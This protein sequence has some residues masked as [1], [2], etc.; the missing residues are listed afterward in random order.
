[1]SYTKPPLNSIPFNFTSSGYS[2]IDLSNIEFNFLSSVLDSTI[3]ATITGTPLYTSEAYT[4]PKKCK[5]VAIQYESGAVQVLSIP[6]LYGGIRDLVGFIR[7]LSRE[8]YNLSSSVFGVYSGYSDITSFIEGFLY[9]GV[10]SD[11]SSNIYIDSPANL[12]SNV[13]S[14]LPSL[15]SA[16]LGAAP[17]GTLDGTIHGYQESDIFANVVL[18]TPKELASYINTDLPY[19]I[20]ADIGVDSP[21]DITFSVFSI[22]SPSINASV[23]GWTISNIRANIGIY[24]DILNNISGYISST[25]PQDISGN[26]AGAPPTNLTATEVG[27]LPSSLLTYLHGWQEFN[28]VSYINN[29][30]PHNISAAVF[31][32]APINLNSY[33]N[34]AAP[35]N[36]YSSLGVEPTKDLITFISGVSSPMLN[37]SIH[38]WETS[39]VSAYIGTDVYKNIGSTILIDMYGQISSSITTDTPA[40]ITISLHSWNYLS[41][42]AFTSYNFPAYIGGSINTDLPRDIYG[43]VDVLKRTEAY[44]YSNMTGIYANNIPTTLNGI[45]AINLPLF[46]HSWQEYDISSNIKNDFPYDIYGAVVSQ[47]PFDL[48]SRLKVYQRLIVNVPTAIHGWDLFSLG[49][50]LAGDMYGNLNSYL[51]TLQR[52]E[53]SISSYLRGWGSLDLVG[54]IKNCFEYNIYCGIN[55]MV[56]INLEA[57]LKPWYSSNILSNLYSWGIYSLS[58]SVHPFVA[59]SLPTLLL[60]IPPF[61][62][63]AFLSAK[64]VTYRQL[65]SYIRAFNLY[66]IGASLYTYNDSQVSA[67]LFPIVSINLGSN[68]RGLIEFYISADITGQEYPYNLPAFIAASGAFYNL[69][70]YIKTFRNMGVSYVLSSSLQGFQSSYFTASLLPIGGFDLSAYVGISSYS[71]NLQGIL[72]PKIV[73]LSKIVDII[74]MEALSLSAMINTGCFGSG[75]LNL[76]S[77][78]DLI[79]LHPLRAVIAGVLVYNGQNNL[80]ATIGMDNNIVFSNKLPITVVT[81]SSVIYN[82]NILPITITTYRGGSI[83]SSYIKGM[84]TTSDLI[85]NITSVYVEDHAFEHTVSKEL[86]YDLKSSRGLAEL[87]KI[88]ELTFKSYVR[89]YIYLQ[90]AN[91]SFNRFVGDKWE[92]SLK[93]YL[94]EN[95]TLHL[96]RR[97]FRSAKIFNLN[98]Y[99]DIDIAVRDAIV[100]IT[101]TPFENLSAAVNL[102]FNTLSY[103]IRALL[104][105]N[106]QQAAQSSISATLLGG[107]PSV[108]VSK[109]LAP[110][111]SEI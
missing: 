47:P 3:A 72:T 103:N 56:P 12:T 89:D 55:T 60:P 8:S 29:D 30:L 91:I 9:T 33:I 32:T 86:V 108:I 51:V 48:N 14:F 74:T 96:K 100:Y 62:I 25:P 35:Y 27:I 87:S 65:P 106:R 76:S 102:T 64:V 71:F 54:Y 16:S 45:S 24:S 57:T 10:F 70:S 49:S 7:G 63:S 6:C 44:L 80:S 77:M 46:L 105:V 61:D 101:E 28:L 68:I 79:Y 42:N 109:E 41:L 39:F 59:H 52:K 95:L 73:R 66:D 50:K 18:D 97:L 21:K 69:A 22:D 58:F 43:Y 84:L 31:T 38:G 1:M 11:L 20:G 37:T 36:L 111:V 53:D 34:I 83:L 5:K 90:E 4:Y 92:V 85:A 98:Q 78:I 110:T 99:S 13:S 2:P 17:V 19:S 107:T 15:L 94:P 26:V 75:Y 88:V 93:S 81:G 23:H 67:Y 40:D 82:Y 104:T